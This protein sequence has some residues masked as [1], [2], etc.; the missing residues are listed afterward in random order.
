MPTSK[1]IAYESG[2]LTHDE[3]IDLFQQL[4]DT[5]IV[6]S[7]QGHYG[8]MAESLIAGGYCHGTV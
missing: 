7:L 2:E 5:G 6:W 4:I 3:V 1:L 8:R